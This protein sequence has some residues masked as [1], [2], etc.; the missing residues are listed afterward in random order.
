MEDLSK[1]RR[2]AWRNE[3]QCQEKR[4]G[5]F[6]FAAWRKIGWLMSA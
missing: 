5:D 6:S 2:V 3:D 1:I 4:R